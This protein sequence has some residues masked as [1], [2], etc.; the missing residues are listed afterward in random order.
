MK[1]TRVSEQLEAEEEKEEEDE[2]IKVKLTSLGQKIFTQKDV[3]ELIKLQNL[4]GS[5]KYDAKMLEFIGVN[6]NEF[7]QNLPE[8]IKKEKNGKEIGL[9]ALVMM[10]FMKN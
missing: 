3:I 4:E 6:E 8:K 10:I 7:K 5:W 1:K 9:T 2:L